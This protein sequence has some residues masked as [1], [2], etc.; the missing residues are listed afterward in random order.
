M[1]SDWEGGFYINLLLTFFFQQ[2]ALCA[3]SYTF[4]SYYYYYALNNIYR[5]IQH[6]DCL[7]IS[8]TL[9]STKIAFQFFIKHCETYTFTHM[10][11][12]HPNG[13][14]SNF[15]QHLSFFLFFICSFYTYLFKIIC[16]KAIICFKPYVYL[17]FTSC[18]HI[19]LNTAIQV[20]NINQMV[21]NSQPD[22]RICDL[23]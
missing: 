22:N 6:F 21:I 18:E 11:D 4:L 19:S 10:Q 2:E 15:K 23:L 9:H 8:A 20:I 7:S 12:Y 13:S 1:T 14:E 17:P 16:L 3:H 5:T